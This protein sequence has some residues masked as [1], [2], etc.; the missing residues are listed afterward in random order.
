MSATQEALAAVR[1]AGQTPLHTGCVRSGARASLLA[2]C[3]RPSAGPPA[4]ARCASRLSCRAPPLPT[5]E[6]RSSV[7]SGAGRIRCRAS[8]RSRRRL[9][10]A[11]RPLTGRRRSSGSRPGSTR[12][13]PCAVGHR[14]A[15]VAHR[16]PVAALQAALERLAAP[17]SRP[18]RRRCPSCRARRTSS[19]TPRAPARL[20][21]PETA[22]SASRVLGLASAFSSTLGCGLSMLHALASR[23][24]P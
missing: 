4:R 17:R 13:R 5:K 23:F 15:T 19:R 3:G 11:S 21:L 12:T 22:T 20:A 18:T 24:T 2:V 14:P 1:A 6:S 10:E 9:G 16:P 7:D 8:R